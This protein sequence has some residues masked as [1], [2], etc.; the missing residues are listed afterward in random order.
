MGK[1]LNSPAS[2]IDEQIEKSVNEVMVEKFEEAEEMEETSAK[3]SGHHF[4]NRLK[5]ILFG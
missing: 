1:E 5:Q 4:F 2:E 3:S